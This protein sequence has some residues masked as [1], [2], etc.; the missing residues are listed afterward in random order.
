MTDVKSH[1]RVRRLRRNRQQ[2]GLKETNVWLPEKVRDAI[3]QAVKKGE[4]PSRRVAITQALE[5]Q[6]LPAETTT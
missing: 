6:F 5:R 4:Y 3:E 1:Q 2:D